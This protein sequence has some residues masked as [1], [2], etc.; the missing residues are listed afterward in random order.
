[1]RAFDLNFARAARIFDLNFMWTWRKPARPRDKILN[2]ERVL[3]GDEILSGSGILSDRA[4]NVGEILSGGGILRDC[5]I[6]S[7]S[8]ILNLTSRGGIRRGFCRRVLRELRAEASPLRLRRKFQ[9]ASGSQTDYKFKRAVV[10]QTG[11]KFKKAASLRTAC[12]F[13]ASM[14]KFHRGSCA[15]VEL[16]RQKLRSETMP[17]NCLKFQSLPSVL[18]RSKFGGAMSEMGA[19]SS[20]VPLKFQISVATLLQLKFGS[21]PNAIPRLKF[22]SAVVAVAALARSKFRGLLRAAQRRKIRAQGQGG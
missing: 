6:S 10:L 20:S 3:R 14:Q 1:M 4:L 17:H 11:R 22:Q 18:A 13:K 8:G 15:V 21:A 16:L 2:G 12:K 9:S 7:G 19:G 5:E